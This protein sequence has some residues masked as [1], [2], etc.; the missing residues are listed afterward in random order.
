MKI[1]TRDYQVSQLAYALGSSWRFRGHRTLIKAAGHFIDGLPPGEAIVAAAREEGVSP[2]S[3]RRRL[4]RLIKQM[5]KAKT[6]YYAALDIGGR[7]PSPNEL[8]ALLAE[9]VK[10]HTEE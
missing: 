9:L 5:E 1:S 6:E 2:L 8:V 3:A 4:S 7:K 10:A